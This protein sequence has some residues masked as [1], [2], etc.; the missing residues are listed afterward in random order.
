[1]SSPSGWSCSRRSRG[2]RSA[3][4]WLGALWAHAVLPRPVCRC[5]GSAGRGHRDR[6]CG[7]GLGGSSCRPPALHGARRASCAGCIR[8][9]PFGSSAFPTAPG[10]GSSLASPSANASPHVNSLAFAL[11]FAA[12]LHNWRREFAAARGEPRRRSRSRASIACRSGSARRP[13]AGALLWS[14][15]VSRR[16][17][18]RNFAP[19][20][21]PGTATGA[22]L[23]DTQWLGF[24]AEAHLQ[25][26]Q[27]DDALTALDR[28]AETAGEPASATIKRSCTGCEGRP[29]GDRRGCRSG[30][31]VPAGDR[32]RPE[33]AGE[34]AGAARRD[35]P[36]PAVARPGQARPG[37]RPARADL[38]LVHR[39][40]R[41]R[42][43]QGRQGAARTGGG[44]PQPPPAG[45][46][47]GGGGGGAAPAARGGGAPPLGAGG[48]A[49]ARG[50]KHRGGD[51]ARHVHGVVAGAAH[52]LAR[53]QAEPGRRLAHRLDALG[54]ECHG[55]RVPDLVRSESR[56]ARLRGRAPARTPRAARR[57]WHP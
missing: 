27:F 32:Y 17:G 38:R 51:G 15:S 3:A 31:M 22:R 25:A 13:C 37:P 10:E 55:R 41:Y 29:G 45:G 20:W 52:D 18:S 40:L 26:G 53:R 34:I 8:P 5:D 23:L 19:A 1:M 47:R 12:L 33:P 57:P 7:R 35:Q 9:G 42:R 54:I 46:A 4:P 30:I 28:A 24:L 11:S 44:D 43:P 50:E 49:L 39:G 21:P 36:R 6:R 56:A 48:A 2:H 16:R 14:A